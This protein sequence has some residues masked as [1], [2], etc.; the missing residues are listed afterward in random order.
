MTEEKQEEQTQVDETNLDI[1]SASIEELQKRI[2]SAK[3]EPQEEE[4]ESPEATSSEDQ[5]EAGS[6]DTEARPGEAP[7]EQPAKQ[8]AKKPEETSDPATLKK[9]VRDK[10]LMLQRQA[11]Q[12]GQLRKAKEALEAKAA[13]LSKKIE[14]PET[15]EDLVDHKLELRDTQQQLRGV[16]VEESRARSRAV[17]ESLIEP[18]EGL[19]DAMLECLKADGLGDDYVAAFNADPYGVASAGEI[20][21]LAQRAK[22]RIR[23]MQLYGM[24]Q[25]LLKER[26]DLQKKPEALL[27]KVSRSLQG[28]PPVAASNGR[29]S[30][31][32]GGIDTPQL[33]GMSLEQLYSGLKDASRRAGA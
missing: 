13:E 1:H 22:E 12:I 20:V 19:P 8:D 15:P 4:A 29:T 11:W 14:A 27:D 16:D 25:Q 18:E 2:E 21:Q 31:R 30:Q 28:G 6:E 32:S 10:E 33:T 23:S 9:Q 26:E 7:A 17:V 3:E 24:V 5:N